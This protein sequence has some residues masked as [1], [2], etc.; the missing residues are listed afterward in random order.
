MTERPIRDEDPASPGLEPWPDRLKASAT[1]LRQT[2][3]ALQA[4]LLDDRRLG[5]LT[6]S[7]DSGDQAVA[8]LQEFDRLL[9]TA[10]TAL[11]DLTGYDNPD[12][13]YPDLA[14]W[15]EFRC[16]NVVYGRH[17]DTLVE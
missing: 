1:L 5:L 4:V 10:L 17:T 13:E 2:S 7:T 14:Q 9:V 16:P 3:L 12:R 11:I 6:D 8:V 15:F